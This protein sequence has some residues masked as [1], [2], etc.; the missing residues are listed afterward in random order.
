MPYSEKLAE[1]IRECI[2]DLPNVEEKNMFGGIA[3]ML[4]GKMCFG[5][6]GDEL[7]CRIDPAAQPEAITKPGCRPM[8]FTGKPM[9][10]YIQVADEGIR[11]KKALMA[12]IDLAIAFNAQAKAAPKKKKKGA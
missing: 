9:K 8:D 10:G 2:A 1:R 3:Y 5:I 4:N 11:T 6:I 12:W 7:M